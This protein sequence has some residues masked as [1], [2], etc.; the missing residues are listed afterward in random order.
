MTGYMLTLRDISSGEGK[1]ADS[2]TVKMWLVC[3][4]RTFPNIC[5]HSATQLKL[6]LRRIM[7]VVCMGGGVA[8]S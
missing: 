3:S 2:S 7:C 5:F 4:Q 1:N 6:H 8:S